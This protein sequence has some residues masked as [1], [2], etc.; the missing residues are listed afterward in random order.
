MKT[1]LKDLILVT[2]SGFF[3]WLVWFL[4]FQPENFLD[5]ILPGLA[6]TVLISFVRMLQIRNKRIKS[7]FALTFGL[8]LATL[9]ERF[10]NL[11]FNNHYLV[12]TAVGAVLAFVVTLIRFKPKKVVAP[13]AQVAQ[14][15]G[16]EIEVK[17]SIAT[18]MGGI[19][20][21]NMTRLAEIAPNLARLILLR[22]GVQEALR[23]GIS[24]Q[25]VSEA[26]HQTQNE[27]SEDPIWIKREQ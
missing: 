2:L 16:D 23:L 8:L 27:D 22:L 18:G 19:G 13:Q 10:F 6:L 25:N 21:E 14:Q 11:R 20:T 24:P 1:F 17:T 9:L 3:I 7:I 4:V 15:A 5:S 26:L 12:L